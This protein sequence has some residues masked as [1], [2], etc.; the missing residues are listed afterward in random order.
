MANEIWRLWYYRRHKLCDDAADK[1]TFDNDPL[2]G[3]FEGLSSKLYGY[4]T[5]KYSSEL[6][7]TY[8]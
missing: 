6:Y 1:F 7:A 8:S 4:A 3:A 2:D 5:E